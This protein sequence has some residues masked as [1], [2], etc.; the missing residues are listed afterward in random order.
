MAATTSDST[1]ASLVRR[2]KEA[3][4]VAWERLAKI[5]A[6]LVYQWGRE[7][8]L[9]E[10]DVADVSQNVFVAVHRSTGGFRGDRSGESFRGWLW[11]ITRN[12][13]LMLYRRKAK[14]PQAAG[15]TDAQHAWQVLPD[16]FQSDTA[17][18]DERSEHEL[19]R[20]AVELLRN[21]FEHQ[22]W[23]AFWL[24]TVDHRPAA[25]IAEQLGLTPGAVRQA[26]YRVLKRLRE[27]MGED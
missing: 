21:E 7:A 9:A 16:Y 24:A 12:E 18:P 3:D 25:E 26:K 20:S 22:T 11:R 2:V 23:Q 10:P 8:G 27:F 6:P 13:V 17:P 15:G 19:L 5:Y 1:S 4:P 14:Q